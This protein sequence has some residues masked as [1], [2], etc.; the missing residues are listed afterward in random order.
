MYLKITNCLGKMITVYHGIYSAWGSECIMIIA[1]RVGVAD[2]NTLLWEFC[3]EWYN[4]KAGYGKLKMP[5]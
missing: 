1:Q 5:L 3:T 4:L 2:E